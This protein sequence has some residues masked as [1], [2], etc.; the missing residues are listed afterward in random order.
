[1]RRLHILFVDSDT[2]GYSRILQ[3]LDERFVVDHVTS[4]SEAYHFLETTFP[5]MI[6]S[7]VLVGQESGLDLC[8]AIRTSDSLCHIPIMLL[9]SRTTLQDK[10]AGFSVGADDYVVKP[11]KAHHLMARIR[12]LARIKRLERSRELQ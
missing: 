11:F 4:L 3:A 5:D 1:L 10:I 6:I 8:Q 12:L 2:S 7:E 9:T